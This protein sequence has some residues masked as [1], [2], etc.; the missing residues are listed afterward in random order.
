MAEHMSRDERGYFL[1]WMILT[2]CTIER[3]EEEKK[4]NKEIGLLFQ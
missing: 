3:E 4:I 1:L 2:L